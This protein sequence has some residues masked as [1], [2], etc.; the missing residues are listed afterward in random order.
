MKKININCPINSTGYG[1]TSFNIVKHLL[2]IPQIDISL[3]PIG[4]SIEVN[5]KE[6][7]ELIKVAMNNSEDYKY[8]AP[9]L[10]IWH[11]FDLASRV[12]QGHYY[13]FPFFEID[14]LTNKEKHHLN[15]CDYIFVASEW[16]KKILQQNNIVKPIYVAPLGVDNTIF[17]EPNKIKV[18]Q[19]NYVFFHIGKWEHRKSHD[20]L[21]QA[22]D[23]AFDIDDNVE[24]RLVPYN[25]FLNE[26]ENNYW[27][28]LVDSCKLK[29][30]IKLFNK[31]PTQYN[32]AEF[33]FYGDCGVFI[34]RA[35]GWNNE[36]IECMSMNKPVIVTDYSAHTEYCTKDNSYLV[37]VDA[38]EPA[39]DGKWFKGFGNWAKL[40]ESQ[41]EQ[42][43]EYMRYVYNNRIESNSQ[44][45]LTAQ[46]YSWNRTVNIINSTLNSNGSYYATPKTRKKR[47]TK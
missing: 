28:K 42:T 13:V 12:G 16:G 29:D 24:L 17:Y 36:I 27:L 20:I 14:T 25:P 18:E 15:G 32:L 33:I 26:Q 6:D 46:E 19:N 34:S 2:K 21:L 5:S 11:Q 35:E 40:G 43:V 10:K 9:C 47:K 23:R 1:I 4:S 8:D 30:K 7:G 22:F 38:V 44:G 37:K 39:N 41:I 45:L 31:L 3:F